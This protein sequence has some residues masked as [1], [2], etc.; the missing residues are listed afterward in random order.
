M[1]RT[2]NDDVLKKV[3]RQGK[4]AQETY[5][6][7]P[8]GVKLAVVHHLQSGYKVL[9][10]EVLKVLGDEL[11]ARL[12][13]HT[14]IDACLNRTYVEVRALLADLERINREEGGYPPA[15]TEKGNPPSDAQ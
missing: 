3:L 6:S 14:L 7:L 8:V 13:M 11:Q 5:E 12:T 15:R 2:H 1:E 9:F 4:K 10:D